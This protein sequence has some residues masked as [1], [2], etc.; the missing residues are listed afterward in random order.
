MRPITVLLATITI[1]VTTAA[2]ATAGGGGGGAGLCRGFGEG[3]VIHLRDSCF[4][5][6]GHVVDAGEPVTV[7]NVGEMPHTI[8]A[9]DGSFDSGI[10]PPGAIYELTFEQSGGVPVYCTLH[11]TADGVGMAGLVTVRNGAPAPA[12]ASD[13]QRTDPARW[14][15][16]GA[17][18]L[19]AAAGLALG[20]RRRG[21]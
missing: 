14:P 6:V 15:W 1:A 9:A 16:L 11:G 10:I 13:S 20:R 2:A 12:L 21:S 3:Q 4:D 18:I 8:T 19:A 7:R 5:G 17:V